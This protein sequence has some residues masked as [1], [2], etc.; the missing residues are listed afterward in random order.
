MELW[1]L[2][3]RARIFGGLKPP[4]AE[5]PPAEEAGPED[6]QTVQR[7]AALEMKLAQA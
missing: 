5:V 3:A 2:E 1:F 4:E 6:P 7:R